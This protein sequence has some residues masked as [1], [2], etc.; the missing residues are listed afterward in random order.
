MSPPGPFDIETLKVL[1]VGDNAF[2]RR[3]IQ[4]LLIMLGVKE[5]LTADDGA[6]A[7][8]Q[9]MLK[10]PHM[11]IADAEMAPFSGFMLVKEIRNS[12]ISMR[13]VPIVLFTAETSAD[14]AEIARSA[15][16]NEV[17]QK[18]V[19]AQLMRKCLEDAATRPRE[20]IVSK[21]YTGPNRRKPA[22]SAYPGPERRAETKPMDRSTRT[23][24][25]AAISECRMAIHRWSESG[26]PKM[27]ESARSALEKAYDT[28]WTAKAD[29]ALVQALAGTMR[30]AEAARNGL[31]DRKVLD[32]S[33]AAARAVLSA[34]G[35]RASMRQALAEAVNEAADQA[36]Q[37]EAS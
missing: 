33:L 9:L 14:Y 1:V 24:I 15:G 21:S 16:A 31:A 20:F 26:E 6:A 17:L 10:K 4:D 8:S 22:E 37:R 7:F 34:S 35:A 29:D 36:D 23:E 19:S 28:A 30:L 3:L 12:P 11:V 5:I 18:P 27:L 2:E 32:V 25:I 13:T